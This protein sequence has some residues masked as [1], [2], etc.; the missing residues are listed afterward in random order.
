MPE[1]ILQVEQLTRRFGDFTAVDRVSFEIHRGETFGF[2]GPNGAGKS[3]TIRMLCGVLAPTEG[4]ASALGRD[5]FTEAEAVRSRMGYMSQKFSLLTDLTVA[6]NLHFFGGLYGLSGERLKHEVEHRLREMQVWGSRDQLVASLSTGE[7][8]RVSLAAAT[9]HA[10]EVLFLD[11]PTSG[12]DPLRRRRFWE[13]MDELIGE[14]MTILVTTHNLS[15]A[16]QCDRL[17]FILAGKLMACGRPREL[18]EGLGRKVIP[19]QGTEFQALRLAASQMPE[20]HSAILQGRTVRLSFEASQNPEPT[21]VRLREQGLN[22]T[23]G[24]T[25]LPS[26]EDLFVDLV[27]QNR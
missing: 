10:P 24:P 17:A 14:G 16:D 8:Q 27:Q 11:E 7:R 3:T 19:L 18:K 20:V 6:E 2:L 12:V 21:L 4:K 22:F 9:L 23:S 5:L 26:L 15:E 1:P 13:A 25:E